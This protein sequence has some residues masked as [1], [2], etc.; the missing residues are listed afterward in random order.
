MAA[1]RALGDELV[2]LLFVDQADAPEAFCALAAHGPSLSFG[3]SLL[4]K[5]KIRERFHRRHVH[6]G[7]LVS[8]QLMIKPALEMVHA[9]LEKTLTVQPH[10]QPDRPEFF[11]RPQDPAGEVDLGLLW[12]QI[13]V[14]KSNNALDGLIEDLRTPAG[15]GAGVVAL[16]PLKPQLFQRLH[17]VQKMPARR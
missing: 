1:D 8:E 9:R 6:L 2:E 4:E 11:R 12:L 3:K 16:A 14:A 13:D 5:S 15:L 7:E 10:P 17:Q